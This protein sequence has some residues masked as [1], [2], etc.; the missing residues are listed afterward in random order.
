[1]F[2]FE[3]TGF[4]FGKLGARS[5]FN[6]DGNSE[7]ARMRISAPSRTRMRLSVCDGVAQL[8]TRVGS[9][10]LNPRNK[11]QNTKTFFQ[12]KNNKNS[13][14][15]NNIFVVLKK[16]PRPTPLTPQPHFSKKPKKPNRQ[17][18]KTERRKQAK[19]ERKMKKSMK[20]G[21]QNQKHQFKK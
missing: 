6:K 21:E 4:T 8:A 3:V 14:K 9:G 19:K 10:R 7:N 18:E 13:K 17:N 20:Q 15:M 1:M 5:F 2:E 12:I 16:K 11:K